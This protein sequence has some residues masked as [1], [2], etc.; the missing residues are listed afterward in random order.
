MDGCRRGRRRRCALTLVDIGSERVP[1][2]GMTKGAP[3]LTRPLRTAVLVVLA[4][5]LLV[6]L[7]P[8]C[9]AAAQAAPIASAMA[10]CEGKGTGAPEDKAPLPACATP[11]TA[12]PGEALARVEPITVLP[13]APWPG[14]SVGLAGAPIP[15][16]TPPP[17]TV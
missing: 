14:P 15:P 17:R 5:L 7:G 12:V 16:A 6:R 13:V 11:C 3:A 4:V 10:G 1:I 9:E 2:R 8:F